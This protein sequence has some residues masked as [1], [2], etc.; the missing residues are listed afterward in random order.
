MK[1]TI[2][3][4]LILTM[5]ILSVSVVAHVPQV[6]KDGES[7]HLRILTVLGT[8]RYALALVAISDNAAQAIGKTKDPDVK[9]MLVAA[10]P[11][12]KNGLKNHR[13]TVR[14]LVTEFSTHATAAAERADKMMAS[15]ARKKDLIQ[16][17][18][19]VRDV[20]KL[21]HAAQSSQDVADATDD[22]NDD[23][24]QRTI[25]KLGE[26]RAIPFERSI[27]LEEEIVTDQLNYAKSNPMIRVFE[28]L[29]DTGYRLAKSIES[30]ES[31]KRTISTKRKL[32]KK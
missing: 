23:F 18:D 14:Y 27:Q 4:L 24:R 31:T 15:G 5:L 29:M 25:R 21:A 17:L 2:A 16:E 13:A 12:S 11:T 1:L 19:F 30:S 3:F 8:I 9:A 28:R 32:R 6:E 20:Q 7:E 10:F 22:R 26:S